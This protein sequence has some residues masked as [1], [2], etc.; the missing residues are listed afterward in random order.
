M[1]TW[2]RDGRTPQHYLTGPPAEF[3]LKRYLWGNVPALDVL[4][5]TSNEGEDCRERNF[6]LLFLASGD[7]RN[8]ILTIP[9]LPQSY[10]GKCCVNINDKDFQVVARNVIMLL[11]A[12][13]MEPDTAVPLIIHIWYSAFIPAVMLQILQSTILPMIW[14]FKYDGMWGGLVIYPET[15]IQ[16]QFKALINFSDSVDKNPKSAAIVMPLYQSKTG[17]ELILNSYDHTEPVIRPAALNEFLAIPGNISDTTAVTNMSDLAA[18]FASQN[19]TSV[20]FGTFTFTNDLRV[21]TTAHEFYKDTLADLKAKT[22]GDWQI[23]TL[24]QPLPH[25]Y[26]KDSAA[27][28]GNVLGLERFD[29][30]TLC[31]K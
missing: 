12:H 7:L 23:Y 8:V 13:R 30:Q 14:T 6:D 4:N 18:A 1:P 10:K 22:T 24:Y 5:L 26:W 16:D 27:R 15:T 31:C 2:H 21:M 29:G 19:G 3:S 25:A 20:Y 11:V 17:M 9:G 28:G